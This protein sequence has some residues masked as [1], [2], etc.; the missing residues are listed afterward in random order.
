MS[1]FYSSSTAQII[2]FLQ[3]LQAKQTLRYYVSLEADCRKFLVHNAIFYCLPRERTITKSNI[4]RSLSK[5]MK[6]MKYKKCILCLFVNLS[7]LLVSSFLE[8]Y[9]FACIKFYHSSILFGNIC[10][11][12]PYIFQLFDIVRSGEN[13]QDILVRFYCHCKCECANQPK[14]K[15]HQQL[16]I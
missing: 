5:Y 9:I 11:Q 16:S 14:R 3:K 6:Y 13:S 10:T 2:N 1:E 15:V 8:N 7:V 4:K 12:V